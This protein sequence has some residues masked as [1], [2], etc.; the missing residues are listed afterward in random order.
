ML[1]LKKQNIICSIPNSL[2]ASEY[3]VGPLTH[4]TQRSAFILLFVRHKCKKE[5]CCECAALLPKLALATFYPE[6]KT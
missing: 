4:F 6:P 2:T 3:K 5:A 1:W